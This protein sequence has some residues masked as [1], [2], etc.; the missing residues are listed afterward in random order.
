MA[1]QHSDDL[2]EPSRRRLLKRIGALGGALAP[3][4][5]QWRM[6]RKPA[7]RRRPI[8]GWKS[9]RFTASIRQAY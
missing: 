1:K 3:A 2:N 8:A 4:V 9:S 6:R 7:R 5:A